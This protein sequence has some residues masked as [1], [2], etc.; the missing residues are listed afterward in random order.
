MYT[1]KLIDSSFSR[2][3][4]AF[5]FGIET[6][7]GAAP[8]VGYIYRQMPFHKITFGEVTKKEK[9]KL[10]FLASPRSLVSIAGMNPS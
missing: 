5:A 4:R 3:S 10:P 1:Q 6:V 7:R 2:V 9:G 8:F